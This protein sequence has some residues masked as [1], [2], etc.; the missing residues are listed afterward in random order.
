L[1]KL[2]S[3]KGQ[4]VHII[5]EDLII[6]PIF[7]QPYKFSEVKRTLVHLQITK[8]LDEGLVKL[9][10]GEYATTIIMIIMLTKKFTF[11]VIGPNVACVGIIMQ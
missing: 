2:A 3:L 1:K 7:K 10:R 6:N 9:F 8:L 4:K 5:L 11:F